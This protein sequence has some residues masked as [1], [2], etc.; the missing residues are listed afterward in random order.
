ML[1]RQI[2]NVL[3][4]FDACGFNSGSSKLF[5]SQTSIKFIS[6]LHI[7][8]VALI[9]LDQIL[10][11]CEF[12]HSHG[13]LETLNDLVETLASLCTYYLIILDANFNQRYHKYF[14]SILHRIET[15]VYRRSNFSL[16]CFILKFIGF[17]GLTALMIVVRSTLYDFL[18]HATFLAMVK[19]CQI[20]ILYYLFCLEVINFQLE[21]VEREIGAMNSISSIANAEMRTFD[22]HKI[23]E[24]RWIRLYL[25]YI[26]EMMNALNEIFGWSHVAAISFC[27]FCLFTDLSYIFIHFSKLSNVKLFG[28]FFQFAKF[29]TLHRALLKK[30]HLLISVAIFWMVHSL[31]IIFY[32]FLSV[33]SYSLAV[34]SSISAIGQFFSFHTTFLLLHF[35]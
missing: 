12:Y 29:I 21:N 31:L 35:R 3:N 13:L 30:N 27:F 32:L 34:C 1:P 24:F 18:K 26:H 20:R 16:R 10:F 23:Q 33:T 9:T 22:S 7:F 15:S 6:V 8:L 2:G 28:N 5:R 14:W 25:Y 11:Y 17:F 4:F 19:I